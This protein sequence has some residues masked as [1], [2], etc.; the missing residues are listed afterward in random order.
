LLLGS[1]VNYSAGAL[2]GLAARALSTGKTFNNSVYPVA[3]SDFRSQDY[4]ERRA[5]ATSEQHVLT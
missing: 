1:D 2:C 4:R 5:D 3:V